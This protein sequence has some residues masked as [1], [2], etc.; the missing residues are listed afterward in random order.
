MHGCFLHDKENMDS[1]ENEVALSGCFNLDESEL[2]EIGLTVARNCIGRPCSRSTKCEQISE[3][4]TSSYNCVV[5]H[6]LQP[7]GLPY[8]FLCP[9]VVW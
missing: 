9:G 2:N 6:C 1:S 5:E 7:G 3:N 8:A 4:N